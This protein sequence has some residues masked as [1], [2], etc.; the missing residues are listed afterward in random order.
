M[1]HLRRELVLIALGLL[2]IAC[3]D[4]NDPEHDHPDAAPATDG[5]A[6]ESDAGPEVVAAKLA[7]SATHTCAIRSAGLYC[8]GGNA[9]GALGDGTTEDSQVAVR[10]TAAGDDVVEVAAQSG[11]T[12]IRRS[13]GEVACWGKN[14]HGQIGDNTRD[15]ALEA[16]PAF[17]IEDAR[18]LAIDERSTCVVHG[19]E[20]LVSCWGESPASSPSEGS[21]F[22]L[23]IAGVSSVEQL[24]SSSFSSYCALD[25]EGEV[26]CWRLRDG[27]WTEPQT[28][29]PLAHARA[30]TLPHPD[31]VCGIVDS[32]K[33]ECH[34]LLQDLR[35]EL[36]DSEGA[37]DLVSGNGGLVA[38][39]MDGAGS[40]KCWNVPSFVLASMGLPDV[41]GQDAL[42][43]VSELAVRELSVAGFRF[44][45][46]REDESVACLDA[47]KDA[48]AIREMRLA[49]TAVVDGLPD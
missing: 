19:S 39:A 15:S 14:D 44:C 30:I 43:V 49:I 38:C 32:G 36:P 9:S 7:S 48:A 21:L 47:A 24:R 5:S 41:Q 10:A 40:W 8:W 28:V 34:G 2:A 13:T 25:S 11:R 17:A 45:S 27:Q 37:V 22:P 1:T 23:P 29:A 3:G 26:L 12:C 4:S 18:Q 46:L 31:Y 33:V 35:I 20:R 42:A 6:M 16:V